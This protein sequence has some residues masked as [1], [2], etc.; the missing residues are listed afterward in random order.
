M[1]N[2]GRG[3]GFVARCT[4]PAL[5]VLLSGCVTQDLA[6]EPALQP[7]TSLAARRSMDVASTLVTAQYAALPAIGRAQY[8]CT[9]SG[10]GRMPRCFERGT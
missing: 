10:F 9:A 2:D 7:G 4:L 1:A 8:I 3:S 6:G 5:C